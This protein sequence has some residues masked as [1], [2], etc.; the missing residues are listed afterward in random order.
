MLDI[1][2]LWHYTAVESTPREAKDGAVGTS[3]GQGHYNV[4]V[5]RKRPA[6]FVN[7]RPERPE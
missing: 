5:E 1:L 2:P 7:E 6:S 4:P 3:N